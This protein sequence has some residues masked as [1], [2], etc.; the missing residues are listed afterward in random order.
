MIVFYNAGRRQN[1]AYLQYRQN[2]Q[3]HIHT[4]PHDNYYSNATLANVVVLKFAT[5]GTL[6]WQKAYDGPYNSALL[7]SLSFVVHTC[8]VDVV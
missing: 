3:I 2:L 4:S 7:E 6:L 8:T 5:N 1:Q